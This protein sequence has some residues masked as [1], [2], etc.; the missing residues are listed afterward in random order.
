MS[1]AWDFIRD[2]GAM[3]DTEYPYT[4]GDSRTEGE[5]AHKSEKTVDK[6]SNY[7]QI[8]GSVAEVKAKLKRVRRLRGVVG[9]QVSTLYYAGLRPALR[10]GLATSGAAPGELEQLE[11]IAAAALWPKSQG[12]SRT[13]KMAFHREPLDVELLVRLPLPAVQRDDFRLLALLAALLAA[14]A[15]AAAAVDL[16]A[17]HAAALD[18]RLALG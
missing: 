9:R 5:C 16:A 3:T 14:A 10:Y 13:A 11:G 8:T 17:P 1:Y 7:G 4:S 18:A 15:A 6:V 2:Q 12:T